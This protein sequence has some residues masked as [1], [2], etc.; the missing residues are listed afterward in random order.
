MHCHHNADG[1]AGIEIVDQVAAALGGGGAHQPVAIAVILVD[2]QSTIGIGD[3]GDLA[4]RIIEIARDV[5]GDREQPTGGV[6]GK[7][8]YL[9]HCHRNLE[10][11]LGRTVSRQKPGRKPA[12]KGMLV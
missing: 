5:A 12:E 9:M 10:A 1:V 6:I 8:M 7:E 11:R 3:I 4:R 2:A